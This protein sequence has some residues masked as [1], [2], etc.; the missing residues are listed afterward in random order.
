MCSELYA[1]YLEFS[2]NKTQVI[3]SGGAIKKNE[4]LKRLISDTFKMPVKKNEINEEA[5]TG[6]ALFSA[7]ATNHIAYN[8]GFFEYIN[9]EK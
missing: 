3:A 6:V 2:V 5:A 4:L 9:G 8:D 7:F 1:L